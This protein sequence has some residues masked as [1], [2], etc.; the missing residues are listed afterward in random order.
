MSYRSINNQFYG[1]PEN[2]GEFG[3]VP[4]VYAAAVGGVAVGGLVASWMSKDDWSVGDYNYYMNQMYQTILLWDKIGWQKGCWKSANRR[5]RWSQFMNEFGKHY[6]AHGKISG[7]SFVSDSEEKPA[8][9]LMRRLAQWGDELNA[10]CGAEIPDVLPKPPPAPEPNA[11][12]DY[13]KYGVWL[14]G[15]LFAL[16]LLGAVRSVAPR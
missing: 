12:I 5:A 10:S 2:F 1:Q 15:G 3:I 6:G 16:Q 13:L 7:A 14:V 8:R 4:L 9:D 11:P